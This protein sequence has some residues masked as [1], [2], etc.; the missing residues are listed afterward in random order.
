[1]GKTPEQL[2]TAVTVEH[3]YLA[4]ILDEVRA[5]RADVQ[6]LLQPAERPAPSGVVPLRE[7]KAKR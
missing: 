1:M 5:L 2:P 7:K 3:V 4:A 6:L